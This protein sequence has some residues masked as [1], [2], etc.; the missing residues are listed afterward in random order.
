ML[1]VGEQAEETE[2][3]EQ[4]VGSLEAGG[5]TEAQ[6]QS[7]VEEQ[8]LCHLSDTATGVDVDGLHRQ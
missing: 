1:P 4:S 8:S 3:A 2:H 7:A 5:F 6:E